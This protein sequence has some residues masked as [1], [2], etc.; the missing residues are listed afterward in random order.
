MRIIVVNINWFPSGTYLP[1]FC[2]YFALP[3][4]SSSLNIV[5]S[6]GHSYA[7]RAAVVY[8]LYVSLAAAFSQVSNPPIIGIHEGILQ[9]TLLYV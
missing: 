6:V 2:V 7:R 3:F 4:R 5:A 8:W 1:A 9:T